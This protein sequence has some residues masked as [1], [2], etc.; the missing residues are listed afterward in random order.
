MRSLS[1][2]GHWNVSLP[3]SASPWNSIFWGRVEGQNITKVKHMIRS[4]DLSIL[5]IYMFLT[6]TCNRFQ[7]CKFWFGHLTLSVSQGKQLKMAVLGNTRLAPASVEICQ[8]SL[9]SC[10]LS[11][12]AI[13]NWSDDLTEELFIL[14][15]SPTTFR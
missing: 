5:Y 11:L 4:N 13:E 6:T 7:E 2:T 10:H 14:T 8:I 3:S 15:L 1:I 12:C 9:R